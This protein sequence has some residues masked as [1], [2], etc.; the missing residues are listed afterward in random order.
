MDIAA[1]AAE[2]TAGHPD[3]GAYT[4]GTPETAA[5]EINLVNRTKNK[6]SLTGDEMFAA[7]DATDW[8]GLTD[9]QQLL[10]LAFTGKDSLDPFAA[11]NVAL[12]TNIFGGGST[13]LTALAALRKE[14]V[15]RAGELG[16]GTVSPGQ[17]TEALAY[18]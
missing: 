2:L 13:T 8:V 17:I 6:T 12:V 10:W 11:A 18:T 15:S 7:T 5:A 14:D 16:L 4:T 9:H 1:L 3:T